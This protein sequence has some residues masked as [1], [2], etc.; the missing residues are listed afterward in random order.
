MR[1]TLGRLGGRGLLS[2]LRR[3]QTQAI[4]PLAEPLGI[5]A[6][7]ISDGIDAMPGGSSG[8]EGPQF[9]GKATSASGASP[10][11]ESP[12][13]PRQIASAAAAGMHCHRSSSTM[14]AE[15]T[16]NR[17]RSPSRLHACML[18]ERTP[19]VV[20]RTCSLRVT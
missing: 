19:S 10:L 18:T 13:G 8:G 2:I 16:G 9:A 3:R 20:Q 15:W 1:A 17:P 5:E 12:F 11:I 14:S 4:A 7:L 6:K